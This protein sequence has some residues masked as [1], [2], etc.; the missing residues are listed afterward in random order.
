MADSAALRMRRSRAHKSGDHSLCRRCPD[1]RIEGRASQAVTLLPPL[2]AAPDLDPVAEMRAL[3]AR[4]VAAHEADP[5]NALLGRELR[6]T[7][8]EMI[9]IEGSGGAFDDLAAEY[10]SA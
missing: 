2:P 3:A 10:G 8:R 7:L 5:S 9:G 1:A 6:M 4:Q